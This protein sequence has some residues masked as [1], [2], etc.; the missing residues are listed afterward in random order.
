MLR[1]TEFGQTGP[2]SQR[3]RFGTLAEGFS[4]CPYVS[5]DADRPR[6]T[7]QAKNGNW[8]PIPGGTQSTSERMCVALDIQECPLDPRFLDDRLRTQNAEALDDALPA[9]I[10]KFDRNTLI[11]LFEMHNATIVPC[12]NAAGIFEDPHYAAREKIIAVED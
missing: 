12:H 9:T 3:P 4:G 7:Y 2:H 11:A 6:D 1:I 8:I 5:S 10:E